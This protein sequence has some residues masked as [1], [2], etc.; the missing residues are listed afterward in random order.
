[1]FLFFIFIIPCVLSKQHKQ[2]LRKSTNL[3]CHFLI[4]HFVEFV[5]KNKKVLNHLKPCCCIFLGLYFQLFLFTLKVKCL[6]H[7]HDKVWNIIFEV[8]FFFLY[9][10]WCLNTFSFAILNFAE[11]KLINIILTFNVLFFQL[12]IL[13]F[14][15]K[16]FSDYFLV[17]FFFSFHYYL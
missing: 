6:K 1:M 7:T 8:S 17:F 16:I 9:F 11:I 5:W 14:F 4:W 12:F 3:F 15:K 13:H 10:V 2:T